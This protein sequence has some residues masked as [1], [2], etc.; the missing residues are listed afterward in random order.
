MN[1]GPRALGNAINA[2]RKSKYREIRELANHIPVCKDGTSPALLADDSAACKQ[3]PL[4]T[5]TRT[6][7]N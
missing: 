2:L 3:G 6:H 1:L 7:A 5:I 4:S